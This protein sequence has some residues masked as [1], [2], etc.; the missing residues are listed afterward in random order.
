MVKGNILLLIKSC[1]IIYK[2]WI[3]QAALS[4]AFPCFEYFA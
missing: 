3:L 2:N 1:I 4:L